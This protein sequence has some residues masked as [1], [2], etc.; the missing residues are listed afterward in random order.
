MVY[1]FMLK[2]GL[3]YLNECSVSIKV[4]KDDEFSI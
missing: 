4:G 3:V 1:V 2:C